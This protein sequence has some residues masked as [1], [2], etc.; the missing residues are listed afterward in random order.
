MKKH[1]NIIQK[2]DEWHQIKHAKIGGTLSAGLYVDS[3]T[4]FFEILSQLSEDYTKEDD[5][6]INAAMQ[7]GN[8]LEPV[9]RQRLE[10]ELGLKFI[11]YGW[12]SSGELLGISP[13]GLTE[14]DQT[15]CEIKCP[16]AKVH[17]KY[18][19]EDVIPKDYIHQMIHLFTVNPKLTTNY[20]CSFRPE[21][22]FHP[23]FVKKMT[24]DSMVNIGTERRP[25]NVII[26]DMVKSAKEA[27]TLL[28][29]K[30]NKEI[31]TLNNF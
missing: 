11:E 5:S 15:G 18:V 31:V 24:L 14:D 13:D 29:A 1:S 20:F 30:L 6:F 19:Y 9:A 7:R 25:K 17:S 2:T 21:N 27:A 26:S 3:N 28:E 10:A 16:S 8:D 22:K 23:L 4:L 12:L